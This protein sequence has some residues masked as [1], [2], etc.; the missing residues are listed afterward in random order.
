MM[1][2]AEGSTLVILA[3][4]RPDPLTLGEFQHTANTS[5]HRRPTPTITLSTNSL[6]ELIPLDA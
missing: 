2:V 1:I 3:S 4:N 6:R 5:M